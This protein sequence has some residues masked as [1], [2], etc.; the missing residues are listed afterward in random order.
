MT[1]K[2]APAAAPESSART[3]VVTQVLHALQQTAAI[4]ACSP[5][6]PAACAMR[7]VQICFTSTV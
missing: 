7:P 6:F 4:G 5:Y 2:A 1:S 3:F